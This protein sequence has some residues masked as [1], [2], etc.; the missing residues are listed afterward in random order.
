M[1]KSLMV[2]AVAA[3]PLLTALEAQAASP[4]PI[5]LVASTSEATLGKTKV[6]AAKPAALPSFLQF[7]TFR[8]EAP[9]D[10]Y[11]V[12]ASAKPTE[13]AKECPEDKKKEAAKG[14]GE[15]QSE[16]TLVGP[17]PIYFAF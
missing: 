2:M 8:S 14:G 13:A 12:T 4:E 7:V 5:D 16:P 11:V 1:R 10:N 9:M 17:E 6:T 15:E 3:L